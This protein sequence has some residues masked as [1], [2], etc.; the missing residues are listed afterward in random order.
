MIE[1]LRD[2]EIP[3]AIALWQAAGLAHPWNDSAR[4]AALALGCPTATILAAH[5]GEGALVGT[6]MAGFDGHRGWLYSLA[7]ADSQRGQGVGTA[8]IRA[9]EDFL[10]AQGAPVIR[11]MVRAG[12]E[13]VSAFY[14]AAGYELGDFLVFGKRF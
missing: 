14:E 8:L 7:V 13:N 1:R 10:R 9:A 4:D 2:D 3:A 6:V 5:D 11:L 12:S